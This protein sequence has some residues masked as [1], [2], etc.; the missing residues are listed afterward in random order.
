MLKETNSRSSVKN[1]LSLYGPTTE[2]SPQEQQ[3]MPRN[4]DRLNI[5]PALDQSSISQLM[6]SQDNDYHMNVNVSAMNVS[7]P[8]NARTYR[9]TLNRS[10]QGGELR[11]KL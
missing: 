11:K 6:Q 9:N 5:L 10:I 4:Y 3:S 1:L 2:S 8:V 7:Q